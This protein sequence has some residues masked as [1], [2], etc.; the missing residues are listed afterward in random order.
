MS[1][2]GRAMRSRQ[3]RAITTCTSRDEAGMI[4]HLQN[5]AADMPRD[6]LRDPQKDSSKDSSR[7]RSASTGVNRPA[8]EAKLLRQVQER[9]IRFINLEFTDVVGMAKSITIPA[10]QL[11]DALASGKW[12]DGSAIEGFARVAE[13]DMFLR[14]DLNTFAEVPWRAA[15]SESDIESRGRV[16]RFICDVLIPGGEPFEGDPRAVLVGAL[17]AAQALGYSYKVAPELEFF[18]FHEDDV[19][20][21]EHKPLP[22]DRGGYFDLSTDLAAD[23]RRE[24]V[25]ELESMRIFV[26]S[27]HHEVA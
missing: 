15:L 18:L 7:P 17:D 24:I 26:E 1:A 25:A 12:F 4:L 19:E 14:P 20:G 23:V 21:A 13:T 22:H 16:A 2:I 6:I 9:D 27:S 8:E 10:D 11:G 5:G 3:P